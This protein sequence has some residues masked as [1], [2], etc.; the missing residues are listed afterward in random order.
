[1][2]ITPVLPSSSLPQPLS[3][4]QVLGQALSSY[5]SSLGIDD[6]NVGAANVSFFQVVALLVSRSS[7]DI[8]QILRDY[9]LDRATGPAL[10]NLAIE[11]GVPP[12]GAKVATGFVTVTDLSFQKIQ[13]KIYAGANPPIAGSTTIFVSDAS[14]FPASGSVYIGRTTVNVEGPLAYSSKA[15]VG[16]FWQLNLSSPT[17]KYHNIGESVILS[18]GG[19]RTVPVNTIVISPG[20][21]TTP[22]ILYSV[23][24]SGIILDG[25]TTVSNI[26]ITA[27]LPGASGNVP[28]GSIS[29]FSGNP[30]GLPNASV[31]NLLPLTTGANTETDNQLRIRVKNKLAST[32]LGTVIAI[33][34]ALQGVQDPGGSDTITSTDILNSSSNTIVY[35]DNGMGLEATHLGVPIETIVNSALG[36][37]KFFQLQTGGKQTSVT[38]SFLQTVA[39]EPFALFGGEVLAVEVGNIAYEHEFQASDFL[40]PGSATAYEVDASINANTTLNFE[41]VS[42]GGGNFVVIRPEDEIT[43]IIKI[44]NPADP[45]VTDANT[46]LQFP[47]QK[48][49]TLRLYKNG[50]L[51]TEDGTTASI[52]TQPQSLWSSTLANGETLSIS[53]DSTDPITYTL[54]DADFVAEGTYTTLSASNSLQSWANVLNNVVTGITASVVGSTIEI[55]SNLG[56]INRAKITIVNTISNPTSL[57]AKGFISISDLTSTGIE[58][59]YILDRNTAQI[60]LSEALAKN[61]SLSAGTLVTQANIEAAT[62]ASGSVTLATDAHVWVSIDTDATIVPTIVGGSQLTV[63]QIS[64]NIVRYTSNSSSAFSNVVPGD[65]VIVWSN[66]IPATD[67]L[68]GRV[69]AHTGS[70][71]D[72]EVTAAEYALVTPVSNA[73]FIQGFVVVRT[74]FVPQKFRVQAGTKTLVVVAAELQTQTDELVFSVFDNTNIKIATNTFD[75]VGQ[76][77]VVTADTSGILLGFNS[78]ENS[79]SQDALIAFYETQASTSDLPL[80][81]HSPISADSYAEP[82]DTYLTTFTSSNSLASFDP[83]DLITF[84]NPYGISPASSGTLTKVSGTGDSTITYSS[85]TISGSPNHY[86]FTVTSAN[87]TIGSVYTNNDV[88]FTVTS[89]IVSGTTLT[90]TG[91]S[92]I[93]DE[94]PSKETVQIAAIASNVV[95]I[96]PEYPDVRRLRVADRF[97]VANPL[98]FGY[99]D[100]VIAIIDNNTVGETYT[101]PL[102]RRAIVNSTY[103]LN[104]YSFNAYDVDAG[105]N[106]NFATNFSTPTDFFANYKALLQAKKVIGETNINTFLLYR[107]VPWGRSGEFVNIAY[108]YPTAANRPIDST[109]IVSPG[110]NV[111]VAISLASGNTIATST[112]ANTQWNVTVT[113]NNPVAGV[114]QV[115]YTYNGTGTAPNLT[116]SGGEYVTILSSTGF[117]SRNVGTF[118]VSSISG[119]TPTSTSFS[120]QRPTGVGFAQTNVVTTVPNGI[121]FYAASPTTAAAVNTYVNANLSQVVTTTIVNGDGSGVLMSSTYEDSSFTTQSFYL[122]DGINWIANSNVSGSPQFTFKE[123]LAYPSAP[124]YSFFTSGDEVRLI[125]T[126]MDQVKDLWNILAVTGFTTVGTVEIV[127][128]GVK[129]QLATNTIGSIGS[130]QIV[131]GSGNKYSVPV[132]TSGQLVGNN[133]M[134]ISAS[135]IA[136]QSVASDQWFRLQA[137]NYQNKSTGISDNTSV[138]V[139]SNSPIAGE[140]TVTLLNRNPDQLYFGTPRTFITVSGSRFRIEKQGSLTCLS[141]TGVGATPVF[142]RAANLNDSGGWTVNISA[143][144]VY[145]VATGATNF[146][147]LSIGDLITVAGATNAGNNGTFFIESVTSTSFGVSNPNSVAETGTSISAGQFHAT[148]SISEGDTVIISGPFSPLNQGSYR[149]IRT[150]NHSIWYENSDSA[151]EEQTCTSNSN[152]VFYQYEA[153]VPGDKLVVNGLVLGAGNAGSYRIIQVVSQTVVVVSGLISS[154]TATNLA[155]NSSSLSIEE[156]TK[157]TGYKQVAFVSAQPGVANFNNIVFNTSPQFEKIDLSAGV[158]LTS[159]GKLDFPTTIRTGIDSYNYDTGLIG[160]A[161]RVVYGDPRD[162]ITYPGVEAAGTDIFIREPLL[163][164]IQIALA[165]RTAIGISFAQITSQIQSSVYSL[166]QANPLGESI[167]LSQIVETVRLIPGVTSVVI[168]SPEYTVSQDEIQLVTGEKAFIANPIT[169]ISVSLIGS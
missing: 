24:Q 9:S 71:L 147:E 18:Q 22:D 52:F 163:R 110:N 68:E 108:T 93:N 94:Q 134:V 145:T 38:K 51:L 60:Q 114:D 128:R 130:I 137:E 156:G 25:E 91:A 152:L 35:I 105:T 142:T 33:E 112:A 157:Y 41:A 45:S 12:L 64:P 10:Q 78:V 98:D 56:A 73:S 162:Q 89:T 58:S 116:L 2:A 59:D 143:A 55:T 57:I 19:V 97:F 144:G 11:F 72:I 21:G 127:D 140:S 3:Y 113:A 100:T 160:E 164:R 168:T 66:E 80:F 13:T 17:T 15:Q 14:T 43:N 65:Y 87:A 154:Q 83:N 37:E 124:G 138:T 47:S 20:I 81:F 29:E 96:L 85:F 26:P 139:A 153:T 67:R 102:Y 70:T 111:S 146:S 119:F 117:N 7:G 54:T 86:V 48:A 101:L 149:V 135:S 75:T 118:K 6:L 61:D 99:N 49:E 129:L 84:L 151:E 136:S 23:T 167:D 166:I 30:S 63:S 53:V 122:L 133:E 90:T 95:T 125:P 39:S 169:D 62:V 131:G 106:A 79:V 8:F 16:S 44:T 92:L 50:I 74:S 103:P 155:G 27:Q 126:T 88:P 4:Q 46:I 28:I 115:T 158:A 150:N 159:L 104:N 132:L 32:G 5:A 34:S 1:M 69:H 123:P 76:I 109:V 148:L 161:N 42:A 120:V 40:N 31:I 141:W 121:S 77:T 107:S 36:G 165:I 82:I